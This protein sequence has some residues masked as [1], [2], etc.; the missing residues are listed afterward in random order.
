MTKSDNPRNSK[1]KKSIQQQSNHNQQRSL[2]RSTDRNDSNR[3]SIYHNDSVRQSHPR[4][5]SIRNSQ[6]L[7]HFKHKTIDN[8]QLVKSHDV[9][10]LTAK[11]VV[12]SREHS[13]DNL[14][15][16]E[17]SGSKQHRLRPPEDPGD[18]EIVQ[19]MLLAKD[20]Y[21]ATQL[22]AV[23]NSLS[24]G[25]M[26]DS[27]EQVPAGAN[28]VFEMD[29]SVAY[30][31]RGKNQPQRQEASAHVSDQLSVAELERH[32]YGDQP[33]QNKTMVS[34]SFFSNI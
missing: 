33:V 19:Q 2:R 13:L 5:E 17:A 32:A 24:H 9:N 25:S 34:S 27:Q 18:H 22:V 29:Q 10:L 20:E 16:H 21:A 6:S 23:T 14:Q 1:N 31:S 11:A 12:A 3:K 7:S 28:P 4:A 30:K 15:V 8:D 26:N